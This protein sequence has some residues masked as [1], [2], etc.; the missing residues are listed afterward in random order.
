MTSEKNSLQN[1]PQSEVESPPIRRKKRTRFKTVPRP[2]V[3]V[4]ALWEASTKEEQTRAHEN[5]VWMLEYWLG[6]ISRDEAAERLGV[7]PLRVWQMSQSAVAG[8][9]CGLLPQPRWRKGQSVMPIDPSND[10]KVLKKKVAALERE[11]EVAQQL[12]DILK[13]LPGNANRE[14]ETPSERKKSQAKKERAA[15]RRG[16]SPGRKKAARGK[17]GGTRTT[18][19]TRGGRARGASSTPSGNSTRRRGDDGA[20]L[21]RTPTDGGS[22]DEGGDGS[23][24]AAGS[25]SS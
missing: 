24:G 7:V 11:L 19:P 10:P 13:T 9:V 3:P 16:A 6:K 2:P 12:I 25:S 17:S 23:C 18:T 22:L 20:S 8:M 21:G 4:R 15:S 1:D 14:L 5:A